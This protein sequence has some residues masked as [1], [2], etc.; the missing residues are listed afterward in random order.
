MVKGTCIAAVLATALSVIFASAAD[1]RFLQTDPVGYTADQ[2]L[3]TYVANDPLNRTDPTGQVTT[4]NQQTCT[5]TADTYDTAHSTGQTTVATPAMQQAAT[6]GAGT[7]AV[8]SGTQEKLGFGVKDAN[9]NLTVQAATGVTTA[10]NA[11]GSTAGSAVP[12]GAEFGIHGHIDTGPNKS[13]GM[14]D[15]PSLNAGF[16]DT[17]SLAL[18]NP[19]PMATVSQGQVGWHEIQNGQLS[20]AAPVGAVTPAQ[21]QAIQNNLN[22]EQM[23]PSFW[24]P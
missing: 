16:G 12:T 3:Y 20:F 15:A 6:T 10:T 5:T 23:L 17:K 13:N 21:Q 14:V 2:N 22:S 9:G 4:C 8:H 24:K 7:V 18:H 11:T 19:M 1:A